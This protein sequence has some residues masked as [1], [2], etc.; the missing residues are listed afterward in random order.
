MITT[1]EMAKD[2]A[3]MISDRIN[4]NTMRILVLAIMCLIFA[5]V[6]VV[7]GITIDKLSIAVELLGEAGHTAS[8]ASNASNDATMTILINHESKLQELEQAVYDID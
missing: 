8:L 7:Q 5:I 6:T 1:K 2:I 3:T 4:A